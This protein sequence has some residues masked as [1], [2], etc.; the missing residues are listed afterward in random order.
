MR[1]DAVTGAP[2]GR[3]FPGAA[4]VHCSLFGDET[5]WTEIRDKA[6]FWLSQ[7]KPEPCI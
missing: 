7:V 1:K 3:M 6:H 2:V 5:L 4:R